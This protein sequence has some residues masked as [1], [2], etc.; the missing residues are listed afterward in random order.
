MVTSGYTLARDLIPQ[1]GK[2]AESFINAGFTAANIENVMAEYQ[3]NAIK[4]MISQ[5]MQ[6]VTGTIQS[7]TDEMH[8]AQKNWESFLQL[9]KD[10]ANTISQGIYQRGG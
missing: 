1:F 6:L 7:A 3:A 5:L 10:F 2:S 4:D 8:A 9:Y